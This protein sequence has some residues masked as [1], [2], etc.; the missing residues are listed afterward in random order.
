VGFLSAKMLRSKRASFRGSV[1][2]FLLGF[3][4][5]IPWLFKFKK[6][7]LKRLDILRDG[8]KIGNVWK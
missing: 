1:S 4:H 7:Q 3:L 5:P 6:T 2:N 8:I